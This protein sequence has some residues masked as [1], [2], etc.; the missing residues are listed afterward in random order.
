MKIDL[1][2]QVHYH[3]TSS[4]ELESSDEVYVKSRKSQKPKVKIGEKVK[5]R[6]VKERERK[7]KFSQMSNFG[8]SQHLQCG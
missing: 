3:K 5:R 4:R 6:E 8:T 1:V 7:S 2:Q